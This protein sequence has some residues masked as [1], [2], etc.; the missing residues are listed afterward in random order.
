MGQAE[1]YHDAMNKIRN[2]GAH[3]Q[4]PV[5]LPLGKEIW[6][7]TGDI[8]SAYYGITRPFVAVTNHAFLAYEFRD[9][10]NNYLQELVESEVRNLQEL[11]EWNKKHAE[12]EL[13][14]GKHIIPK[15]LHPLTTCIEFPSQSNLENSLNTTITASENAE[16]IRQVRALTRENGVD[17]ALRENDLDVIAILSDSP[18]SSVAS[19]SGQCFVI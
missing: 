14:S 18:L 12:K 11:V 1:V 8:M 4:Y 5:E 3:T 16:N 7:L 15:A 17:K 13:P 6:P 10:M 19:G 9:L 2:A